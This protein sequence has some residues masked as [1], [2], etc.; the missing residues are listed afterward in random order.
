MATHG[1]VRPFEPKEEDWTSYTER[2][3]QYFTANDVKNADK[4]RGILLSV[5]GAPTY[6]LI[7]S[8]LHPEKPSSKSFDEL[9]KL[10][11]D[12]HQP[13]PSESIQ[14]FNFNMHK[15]REGETI[16]EYVA[17]TFG[18]LQFWRNA[19]RHAP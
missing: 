7:C 18:T 12:H 17:E 5:C 16:S 14:R 10:V 9:V 15:Q 13:T 19:G 11:K 6:K 8:L 4:Q 1:S 3:Q 2:L